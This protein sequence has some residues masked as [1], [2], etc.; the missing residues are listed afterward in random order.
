MWL[1]RPI[2]AALHTTFKIFF[3]PFDVDYEKILL[4]MQIELIDLQ[5][6]EDLKSKL[7]VISMSV[8]IYNWGH[9]L[10]RI[11]ILPHIVFAGSQS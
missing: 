5:C 1:S 8:V 4:Q 2:H 6:S 7:L 3:L 10:R 11:R 9:A